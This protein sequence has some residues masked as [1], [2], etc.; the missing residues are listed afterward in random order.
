MSDIC[1]LY[2]EQ[3]NNGNNHKKTTVEQIARSYGYV[4]CKC[5]SDTVVHVPLMFNR[6]QS[7]TYR[8]S[9]NSRVELNAT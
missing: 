2:T 4:V 3:N 8:K 5:D 9:E 6:Y 7:K 1:R